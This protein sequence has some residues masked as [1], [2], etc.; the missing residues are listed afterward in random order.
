MLS[1]GGASGPFVVAVSGLCVSFSL[2]CVGC[3]LSFAGALD[4]SDICAPVAFDLFACVVSDSASYD[5]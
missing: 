2:C 3:H 5:D 1:C 4:S